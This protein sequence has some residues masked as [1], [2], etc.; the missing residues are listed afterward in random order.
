MIRQALKGKL[1]SNLH[2]H[3][4][5]DVRNISLSAVSAEVHMSFIPESLNTEQLLVQRLEGFVW[6]AFLVLQTLKADVKCIL[7]SPPAR[8]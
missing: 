3:K 7:C 1:H 5:S 6:S 8:L 2:L 4:H